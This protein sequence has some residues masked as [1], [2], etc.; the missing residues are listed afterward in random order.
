MKLHS[1]LLVICSILILSS[2]KL[3]SVS[4]AVGPLPKLYTEMQQAARDFDKIPAERKTQIKKIADYIIN[5]LKTEKKVS[6]IYICVHNSD[7][8]FMGQLWATAAANYYGIKGINAYSGGLMI[9]AFNP[10]VIKAMNAAGFDIEKTFDTANPRYAAKYSA[11]S[12]P[13]TCFSK[14][15]MDS[16][17]PKTDFAAVTTCSEADEACPL[18]QGA[19]LRISTPYKAVRD[20]DGKP[21]Q[22]KVYSER[23]RQ[24]ETEIMYCFSLVKTGK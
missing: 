2:F 1:N 12:A 5:K 16:P 20:A 13:V 4:V 3:P 18:V 6:L 22:D 10:N 24:M 19:D 21:D 15:Y 11:D 23:S 14:K 9:T 8:S 7:R 17:N